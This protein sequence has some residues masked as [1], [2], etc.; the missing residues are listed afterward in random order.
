[1]ESRSRVIT[2]IVLI[3]GLLLLFPTILSADEKVSFADANLETA[4]RMEIGKPDGPILASELAR[5]TSLYAP[6]TLITSLSGLEYCVDLE[7]LVLDSDWEIKDL[8][9]ISGL[10]NLRYLY[11]FFNDLSDL[12]P[13][14]G[15]YNLE[16]LNIEDNLIADI[17]P[18]SDLTNLRL[19]DMMDNHIEDITPLSNLVNLEWLSMTNNLVSDISPLAGLTN[20]E[21]LFLDGNRISDIS[22]L[23]A[24]TGIGAGDMVRL[25]LNP[26][27]AASYN[28]YLPQLKARGVLGLDN[29]APPP[30]VEPPEQPAEPEAAP[31]VPIAP[32]PESTL[33]PTSENEWSLPLLFWLVLATAIV[34]GLFYLGYRRRRDI[35]EEEG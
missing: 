8:S 29:I 15:L 27:S 21:A 35:T 11:L 19:L 3:A 30:V 20:L 17:S 14:S 13:L 34:S 32:V 23:S 25:Q 24:N 33:P 5:I 18:L 9:P 10:T 31:E 26:L 28:D 4:V 1:M 2:V 22:P 6:N 16:V 12:S 7:M